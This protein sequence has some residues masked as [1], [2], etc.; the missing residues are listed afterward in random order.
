[1]R[2][3][4][5]SEIRRYIEQDQT[6]FTPPHRSTLVKFLG[7]VDAIIMNVANAQTTKQLP[8]IFIK[9]LLTVYSYWTKRNRLPKDSLVDEKVTLLDRADTWLAEGAWS[10]N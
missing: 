7:N 4:E 2:K 10:D 3:G 9:L 8:A 5:L 1:L 6:H